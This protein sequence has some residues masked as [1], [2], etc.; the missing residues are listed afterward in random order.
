MTSGGGGVTGCSG[1]TGISTGGRGPA[2]TG[3]ALPGSIGNV[4]SAG[5][6]G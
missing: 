1:V 4:S 6:G 3:G 2:S 5:G